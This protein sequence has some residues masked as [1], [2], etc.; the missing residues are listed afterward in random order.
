LSDELPAAEREAEAVSCG[1]AATDLLFP[2]AA[3]LVAALGDLVVTV[4]AEALFLTAAND[5]DSLFLA[6][7]FDVFAVAAT[8]G[9]DIVMAAMPKANPGK[10]RKKRIE[11]FIGV[12][13]TG[14][15][16]RNRVRIVSTADRV[17][18]KN[19][20]HISTWN[21]FQIQ[22]I[23]FTTNGNPRGCR[24]PV[25]LVWHC[26]YQTIVQRIEKTA[27]HVLTGSRQSVYFKLLHC[28]NAGVRALQS[29]YVPV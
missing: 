4:L 18:G 7:E 28:T 26:M 6:D 8:A 23:R 16:N 11:R 19:P 17:L 12:T 15:I 27:S 20:V 14:R 1:R 10:A 22:N 9:A 29:L 13:L 5:D 25:H 24:L 2:P 3:G 21:R